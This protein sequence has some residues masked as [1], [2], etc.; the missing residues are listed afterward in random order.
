MWPYMMN[1]Y[2]RIIDEVIKKMVSIW[3]C[4]LGD[5]R[6]PSIRVRMTQFVY[7]HYFAYRSY[8]RYVNLNIPFNSFAIVVV[9]S[10]DTHNVITQRELTQHN[11]FDPNN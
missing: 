9:C 7:D 3:V 8:D 4:C 2:I 1:I 6:M 5:E 11:T 10:K